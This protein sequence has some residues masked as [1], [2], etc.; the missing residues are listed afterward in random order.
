MSDLSE[1]LL[2]VTSVFCRPGKRRYFSE[3]REMN[4]LICVRRSTFTLV[5]AFGLFATGV[6]AQAPDDISA[7]PPTG[8]SYAT[9]MPG[10]P[11]TLPQPAR[12]TTPRITPL[13]ESQWTDEQ[14]ATYEEFMG[15][16]VS[17]IAL[18]TILRVPALANVIMPFARYMAAES[19]LPARHRAILILRTAWLTQSANI[20]ATIAREAEL[21]DL[22]V[23][24]IRQ[25]AEGRGAGWSEFEATLIQLAD[26]LFRNS[27]VTDATWV[28][29]EEEYN[30][31]NMMDAAATVNQ[32]VNHSIIF[33]SLG[34]QAD[35]GATRRLP[36]DIAYEINMPDREPRLTRPRV[37]PLEGGGLRVSRTFR[38]HP[39]VAQ[40]GSGSP[41]TLNPNLSRLMPHDR[42]LL[43]LRTGWNA[44]A[45]YEWAKHVGSVGRARENGLEPLWIAQGREASG[46]SDYERTLVIAADEMFRDTMISDATWNTLSERYD[47]H[48]MISIAASVGRYR[49]VSMTLN[50][51]G[52][53]PQDD[54]ELFPVLEGR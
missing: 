28:A 14:A 5:V 37:D 9:T 40:L 19:T 24:E 4:A 32:T 46:W 15:P 44:Q 51:L 48:Q 8:R 49:F 21:M 26:E 23:A 25:V 42:E 7:R 53:Q 10:L 41:Y 30:L 45:V 13:P 39:R 2:K 29:L 54:D 12:L 22:S 36:T 50:A 3:E 34:I 43:I 18:R 38:R 33:N 31:F 27:S 1:S 35:A 11:G 20:W 47:T 52:V 16:G 17:E 6:L